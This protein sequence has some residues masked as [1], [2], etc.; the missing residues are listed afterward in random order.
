LI[1]TQLP[2]LI[3]ISRVLQMFTTT[4][5]SHLLHVVIL[6]LQIK[7]HRVSDGHNGN[8]LLFKDLQSSSCERFALVDAVDLDTVTIPA[9]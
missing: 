7:L 6:R 3:M 9:S 5:L 2:T 4:L 1:A 8:I